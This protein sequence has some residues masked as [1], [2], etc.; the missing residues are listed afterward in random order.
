MTPLTEEHDI[1]SRGRSPSLTV[2]NPRWLDE[3]EDGPHVNHSSTPD[4]SGER[5][6]IGGHRR[7]RRGTSMLCDRHQRLCLLPSCRLCET[8]GKATDRCGWT[9]RTPPRRYHSP[10]CA[11]WYHVGGRVWV[12]RVRRRRL[13]QDCGIERGRFRRM[14]DG[15]YRTRRETSLSLAPMAGLF[16]PYRYA[17]GTGAAVG[18]DAVLV[19][20]TQFQQAKHAHTLGLAPLQTP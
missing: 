5:H 11:E 2:A 15:D 19:L 13:P 4:A 18:S 8:C 14:P 9:L 12:G 1:R 3:D 10:Q 7:P 17:Y 20:I 16:D 6:A